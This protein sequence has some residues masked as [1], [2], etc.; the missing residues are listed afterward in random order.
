M[1]QEKICPN[2]AE[3]V[4]AAAAQCRY[5][6]FDF[7][8]WRRPGE[9]RQQSAS[10]CGTVMATVGVVLLGL[11]V[12]GSCVGGDDSKKPEPIDQADVMTA[13]QKQQCASVLSKITRPSQM[14]EHRDGFARVNARWWGTLTS[15]DQAQIMNFIACA[16]HGLRLPALR[17]IDQVVIIQDSVTG[18]QLAGVAEGQI[19]H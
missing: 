15:D 12:F 14:V 17:G 11:I 19:T 4:K 2:C 7:K 3:R 13:E 6:G 1:D 9:G 10:G 18:D 16:D 8:K 5:C